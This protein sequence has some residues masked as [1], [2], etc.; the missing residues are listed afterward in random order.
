[1]D[2]P[3]TKKQ[4]EQVAAPQTNTNTKPQKEFM[5]AAM[6]SLFLGWFGIDRFY[7]GYVGTG[8]LKLITFGGCGIWYLIDLILILT[9]SLKSSDH[10]DLKGRDK[11]LKIAVII[12]A[13]VFGLGLIM[14][15]VSSA[16]RPPSTQ[17]SQP[18]Q[19]TEQKAPEPAKEA[20]KPEAPPAPK[21][22]ATS[23]GDGTYLVG[24][25]I[26]PGTYKTDN[27]GGF[28]YYER[29]SGVSGSFDDIITNGS[30][31]GPAIIEIPATDK[32]FKTSGCGTWVKS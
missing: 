18:Q 8:I 2:Q 9:G 21:G 17:T 7:L 28:C 11:N 14:S 25:E 26:A 13:V 22:P 10:Q 19:Q 15:I 3:K 16:T 12:T 29:L 4:P 31:K 24:T 1:M 27:K 20:P 5:V 6:L 23:F 30:P 32:A